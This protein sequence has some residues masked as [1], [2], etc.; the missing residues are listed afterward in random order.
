MLEK[1]I[2]LKQFAEACADTTSELVKDIDNPKLASVLSMFAMTYGAE[3][4]GKL[5]ADA[6]EVADYDA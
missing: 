3:L 5:F 1:T 2:S 6:E 4:S